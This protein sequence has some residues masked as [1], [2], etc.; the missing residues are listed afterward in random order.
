M[1]EPIVHEL[2]RADHVDP[3]DR[4]AARH[5]QVLSA[6]VHGCQRQPSTDMPYLA[7][8]VRSR[9]PISNQNH[10]G[11]GGPRCGQ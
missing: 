9:I 10:T 5:C 1:A 4:P 6:F 3:Q 7:D 11:D 2:M 8:G